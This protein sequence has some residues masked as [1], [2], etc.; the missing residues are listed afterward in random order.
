MVRCLVDTGAA[1]GRLPQR[2]A[3]VNAAQVADRGASL[4]AAVEAHLFQAR[5]D[6]AFHS[7][8]VGQ[9]RCRLEGRG[10]EAS[11]RDPVLQADAANTGAS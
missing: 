5:G 8:V 7:L 10:G 4:R 9:E 2:F 11:L 1:W 6:E 3:P